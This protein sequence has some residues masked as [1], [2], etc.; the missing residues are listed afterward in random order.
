MSDSKITTE[1]RETLMAK[2]FN[3]EK[4]SN[5]NK[6]SESLRDMRVILKSIILETKMRLLAIDD[7]LNERSKK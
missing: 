7:E 1:T 2:H 6:D 4:T 5:Y 3:D